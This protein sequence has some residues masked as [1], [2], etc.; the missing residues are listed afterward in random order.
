MKLLVK[1]NYRLTLPTVSGKRLPETDLFPENSTKGQTTPL[2]KKLLV[3]SNYRSNQTTSPKTTGQ[4]QLT[5]KPTHQS[6]SFWSNPATGQTKPNAK[7]PL[8]KPNYRSNHTTSQKTAGQTQ[9]PVK[10]NPKT[11]CQTQ[12]LKNR[13]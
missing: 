4:I 3:K 11:T 13:A 5:V 9:P 2:A 8:V 7:K 6:K 1:P 12:P 10:P